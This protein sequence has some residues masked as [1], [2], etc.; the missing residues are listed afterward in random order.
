MDMFLLGDVIN[1]AV[2]GKVIMLEI[3]HPRL[4]IENMAM[5]MNMNTLINDD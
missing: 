2:L 5:D 4:V 3:D 1:E